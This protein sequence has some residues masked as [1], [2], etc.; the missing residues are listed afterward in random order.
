MNNV[1]KVADLL[2]EEDLAV[3]N[4]IIDEAEPELE[5]NVLGRTL[6][7]L[8]FPDEIIN[9]ITKIINETFEIEMAKTSSSCVIYS[10]KYGEPNL[11]P[12]FDADTNDLIVDFQISSN[13]NWSIGINLEV[14]KMEDN[15]ALMFNPNTNIHWRPHKNFKDGEYIKMMFLRFK[16]KEKETDY[17][18]AKLSQGHPIFYKARAFRDS[19]K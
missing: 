3:I 8:D 6:Y 11:P 1:Y 17:S 15:S 19:L 10:N 7:N 12:H 4:K 2:S 13:T 14:Y 16:S 18:Y 5:D 9:K